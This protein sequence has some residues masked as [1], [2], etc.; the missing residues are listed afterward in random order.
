MGLA[1]SIGLGVSFNTPKKVIVI[2]GD[3]SL[4]M[5]PNSLLNIG[6]HKPNNLIHVIL[7]NEAY[8][9]CSEEPS[10]M[11]ELNLKNIVKS[12]GYPNYF[13]V[14]NEK[15]LINN[16][17]EALK[18][19]ELSMIHIKISVEGDRNLLRPLNLPLISR[20]FKK[21]ITKNKKID[22]EAL[23]NDFKK[24]L[25]K[26][27]KNKS[28]GFSGI[29]LLLYD[30]DNLSNIK[31]SDL[32]PFHTAPNLNLRTD[33]CLNYLLNISHYKH[34][35][36]DGF[37]FFNEQGILTHISQFLEA[38]I[39]HDLIP[40]ESYGARHRSAQYISCVP[41]VIAVGVI[42]HDKIF[43]CSNGEVTKL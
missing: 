41:G 12:M 40:N 38:P 36:H 9:S 7:D 32:R 5:N 10:L 43:I 19:N 28:K 8:G 21:F 23:K 2:E 22:E 14:K 26:L 17:Q 13:F 34:E 6:K 39:N 4:L 31:C 3:A 15:D 42:C 33:E 37:H 29:G 11:K 1:S 16:F 20:R 35:L 25:L 24:L 30:S 27:N 18:K